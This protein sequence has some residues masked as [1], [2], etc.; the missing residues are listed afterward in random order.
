M[1]DRVLQTIEDSCDK[2][3]RQIEE[4]RRY[5]LKAPGETERYQLDYINIERV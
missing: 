1:S 5:M 3:L 2:H 4:R